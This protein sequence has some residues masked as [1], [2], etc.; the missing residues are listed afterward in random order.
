M[1]TFIEWIELKETRQGREGKHHGDYHHNKGKGKWVPGNAR[2]SGK[3][4]M[5]TSQPNN[6]RAKDK[7]RQPEAED[8]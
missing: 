3:G 8:A 6:T 7:Q 5:G 2:Y 4:G 1:I